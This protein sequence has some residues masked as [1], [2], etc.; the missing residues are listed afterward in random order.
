LMSSLTI[1][2]PLVVDIRAPS[3]TTRIRLFR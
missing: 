3:S 2:V 1:Y